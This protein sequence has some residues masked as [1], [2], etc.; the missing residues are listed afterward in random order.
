MQE[1]KSAVV[2]TVIFQ[3]SRV[4]Q[5]HRCLRRRQDELQISLGSIYQLVVLPRGGGILGIETNITNQ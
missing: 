2:F 1:S 4:F 5:K 3:S